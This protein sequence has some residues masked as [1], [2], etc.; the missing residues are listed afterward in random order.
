M[1]GDAEA[2]VAF[3]RDPGTAQRYS[4]DTKTIVLAGHSGG[5]SAAAVTAANIEGIRGIVLISA[6][7][8]EGI[9]ASLKNPQA[10]Q[11]LAARRTPCPSMLAGCTEEGLDLEAAE[12]APSWGF[13]AIAPRL[14]KIPILMFTSDDGYRAENDKLAEEIVS[15]GGAAPKRIYWP[16]DHGYSDH[17]KELVA[18]IIQWLPGN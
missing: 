5:A 7:D 2:A 12:H 15:K 11:A 8:A 13:A 4:I 6:V 17:R 10:R 14:T 3:V 1:I 9:A 16:T 18:A